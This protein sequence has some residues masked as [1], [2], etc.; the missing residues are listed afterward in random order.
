M[1]TIDFSN[2]TP[3]GAFV[4]AATAANKSERKYSAKEITEPT[5]LRSL[6]TQEAAENSSNGSFANVM[7]AI[8]NFLTTPASRQEA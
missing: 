3:A 7:A 2:I 4:N 8:R 1:F 5:S 6:A